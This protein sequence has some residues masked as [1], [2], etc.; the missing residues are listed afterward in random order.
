MS[1]TAISSEKPS[2]KNLFKAH[3]LSLVN[4]PKLK[5][6]IEHNI[7]ERAEEDARLSC[8][9]T[10]LCDLIVVLELWWHIECSEENDAGEMT[11]EE[12]YQKGL[13]LR[14]EKRTKEAVNEFRKVVNAAPDWADAWFYLAC[15]CDN[16]GWESRA[17]PSYLKAL[18]LGLK[19]CTR[20]TNSLLFLSSSLTKVQHIPDA[21]PFLSQVREDDLKT[22]FQQSLHKRL[23]EKVSGWERS[24]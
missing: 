12:S 14:T 5:G 7:E 23:L 11:A 24:A 10:N 19:D 17:I 13:E 4:D 9:P 2:Q 15:S 18:A 1:V 20:H 22:D 3:A 21:A 6:W 16:L 8:R